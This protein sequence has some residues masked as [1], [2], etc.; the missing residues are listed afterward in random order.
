MEI[1]SSHDRVT[2]NGNIKSV[3]HYQEIKTEIENVLEKLPDIKSIKIYLVDSIIITSSVIGFFCKLVNIDNV[4]IH[5][6]V[7]DEGLYDLLDDLNIV[8]LLNVQKI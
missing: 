8:T 5:L 7:H 2:I 3:S 6:H 4:T 1:S